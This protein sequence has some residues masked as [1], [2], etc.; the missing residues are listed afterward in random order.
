MT[1][2]LRKHE[3]EAAV[4]LYSSD[5]FIFRPSELYDL[6]DQARD[7]LKNHNIYFI[8]RRNKMH[9]KESSVH[10]DNA[11]DSINAI[12]V[13]HLKMEYKEI[14][15][16]FI[17]PLPTPISQLGVLDYP[18]DHLRFF[19]SDGMPIQM[20]IMDVLKCSEGN[21]KP[22]DDILIE[23]IGQGFGNDG[24]RDAIDRLIGDGN[25]GH[26]SLQKVLSDIDKNNPDN[27]AFILLY[28]FQFHKC[29][30]FGGGTQ[31]PTV[32]WENA[33]KRLDH[34][35][36]L[37]LL[38]GNRINLVEAA[39]IRYFSP[40]YNDKYKKTFPKSTHL[41]LN[42]LF[43]L[44]VTGL[45]VSLSTLDHNINIFSQQV[46]ASQMHH[47]K[48]PITSDEYRASFFDLSSPHN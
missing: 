41:I 9:I 20:R 48:Y 40:K 22:F 4:E 15:I 33:P 10:L 1:H 43:D 37:K 17:N 3:I 23:Y 7:A 28:S 34:F 31:E 25:Q 5:P 44:D 11:T 21:F 12:L 18:Y 45:S 6:T 39:L 38:R 36:N 42:D 24:S 16:K 30:V 8:G 19:L 26:A 46:H 29:F 2:K 27:E 35:M 14:P 47:M 13:V 32:S